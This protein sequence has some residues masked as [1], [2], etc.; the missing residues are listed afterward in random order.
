M[1]SIIE[2]ETK[3]ECYRPGSLTRDPMQVKISSSVAFIILIEDI[4]F[5]IKLLF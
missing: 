1:P 4:Y 2:E 3:Q 5:N